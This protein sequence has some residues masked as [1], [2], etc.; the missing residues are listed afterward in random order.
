[1]VSPATSPEKY[2]KELPADRKQ[3]FAQLTD[4]ILKNLPAGL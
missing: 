4:S 3:V 1:V 2:I